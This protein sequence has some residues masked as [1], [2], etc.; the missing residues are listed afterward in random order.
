MK[1]GREP[2][3]PFVIDDVSKNQYSYCGLTKREYF[4]GLALQG[5][6]RNAYVYIDGNENCVKAIAVSAL[7]HADELLSQLTKEGD[8]V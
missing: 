3:F 1:N 4:A 6:M 7:A 5:L 2:A 8:G